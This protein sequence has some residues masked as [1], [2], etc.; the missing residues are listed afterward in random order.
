MISVCLPV[1]FWGYILTILGKNSDDI[2]IKFWVG[3]ISGVISVILMYFFG[4][5][6]LKNY[7]EFMI[8]F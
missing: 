6:S 3:L 5:I 1:Y 7:T 8:W 4:K 2:R